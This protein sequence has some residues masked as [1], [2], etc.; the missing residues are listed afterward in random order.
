MQDLINRPG[1]KQAALIILDSLGT[2]PFAG[3]TTATLGNLLRDEEQKAFNKLVHSW[4]SIKEE[5]IELISSKISK[6]IKEPTKASL[7]LLVG[8]ILG[9]NIANQLVSDSSKS[10][11]V[12]L[13][14]ETIGELQVFVKKG[15]IELSTTHSSMPLGAGNRI[16]NSI[17]DAK[18]NWGT[19]TGFILRFTDT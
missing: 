6:L 15:W 11:H 8:E 9:D 17:E 1:G 16:G 12:M 7:A 4:V 19:G 10:A 14:S 2:I 3:G 18:R 5:E 13:N